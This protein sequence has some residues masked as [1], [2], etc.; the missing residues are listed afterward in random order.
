[1]GGTAFS[2]GNITPVAEYNFWVDPDAARIVFN[3][4]FNTTMVPW[5]VVIKYTID[6]NEWN[7]IKI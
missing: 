2:H 5:D 7:Q 3:A 4:G 1:M 6:D